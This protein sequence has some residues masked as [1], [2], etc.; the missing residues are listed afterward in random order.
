MKKDTL[1]QADQFVIS[2]ELLHVLYWLLKYEED[3]LSKLISK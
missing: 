3:E 2:Y 1:V